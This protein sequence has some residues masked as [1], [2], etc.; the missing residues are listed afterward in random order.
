M[1]KKILFKKIAAQV[2]VTLVDVFYETNYPKSVN[3]MKEDFVNKSYLIGNKEIILGVY[4]NEEERTAAFFHELGHIL[5]KECSNVIKREK[6]AWLKGERLANEYGINFT[7]KMNE[8]KEISI[9]SYLRRG[10]EV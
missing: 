10:Y 4:D 3:M 9:S 2:G 5:S 6:E 1:S 8:Y 7:P